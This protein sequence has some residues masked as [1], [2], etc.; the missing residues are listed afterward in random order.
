MATKTRSTKTRSVGVSQIIQVT[1]DEDK[2]T[3]EFMKEFRKSFYPFLSIN[4]HVEHLAQLY[5]RGAVH[6]FTAFI[7]GYGP[8]SDFGIKFSEG[9]VEAEVIDA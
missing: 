3:P 4:D 1:V 7:E 2:F 9:S 6:D 8:P 5:V